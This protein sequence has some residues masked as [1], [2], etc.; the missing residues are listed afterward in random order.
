MNYQT[1]Q[2]KMAYQY[3]IE[4]RRDI[5]WDP[6]SRRWVSLRPAPGDDPATPAPGLSAR[7]TSRIAAIQDAESKGLIGHDAAEAEILQ[8]IREET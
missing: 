3:Y 1:D 7:A 5:A 2:A 8:I 4:G 6:G